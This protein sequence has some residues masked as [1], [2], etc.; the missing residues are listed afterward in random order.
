[1]YEVKKGF[2]YL[3]GKLAR[4]L[5]EESI[6][7]FLGGKT[8]DE[9]AEDKLRAEFDELKKKSKDKKAKL[10][11]DENKRLEELKKLIKNIDD[12][13]Y[14]N[15]EK[16]EEKDETDKLSKLMARDMKS[17]LNSE[18]NLK[19]HLEFT[20][21]KVFTRFPP[22]P[23]GYLH[24]GHA[25]AMRFNFH[26][27]EVVGGHTYLRYDDTNPEKETQEFITNIEENVRWLG[28][29]PY[30][31]TYA[32][33]YFEDLYNLACELIKRG[34]AFVCHQ[35]KQE[36]NEYRVIKQDS[37]YRTRSVEENLKLFEMMRQGRFDE[38][39][40]CLRMK[41][42]MQHNNPCMRDPV[43]YRIKYVPHPHAGDKW[44]IYPTYDFTHCI[45]DS[46]ENI[47]HSLCTLE[48]EI[49]RDSY[50]WLL[51]ALDL[52]RPFV[53]EYSRLNLTRNVLS[54]RK[55]TQLVA[56]NYVKGWDDPR[57]L[58]INGL[59]RRGYTAEAINTFV[60]TV[61]VAR[62]GNDKILSIKLLEYCIRTDLDKNEK[63]RA[64][65][66]LAVVDPIKVT[67]VNFEPDH[68]EEIETPKYPMD[69]EKSEKRKIVLS[70][71]IYIERTDFKEKDEEDFYGL[72][73]GKE[74]GLK[75]AS[76]IKC[77]DIVK[78]NNNHIKELICEYSKEN[79]NIKG[80]IHWI[81][82]KDALKC[83]VRLY[84]YLFNSEDPASL[85]EPLND[86]NQQSLVV[87]TN[88]LVNKSLINEIKEGKK[89][90]QFERLGYF[91]VDHDSDVNNNN[92]VFNLTVDLGDE[93]NKKI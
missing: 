13:L 89:H 39:V 75:Y 35:T 65:R 22:E 18:A 78:D 50:Y 87:R 2:P 53:W 91:V 73:P 77:I 4:K 71:V 21:G 8:N 31:I 51:E 68:S 33:D 92:L 19:K 7:K 44:C 32:S 88:S 85:D 25:K 76:I 23:N 55:L 66:T 81:S 63:N 28:Y 49:R 43:A 26:S 42:D 16:E 15:R 20:G 57:M 52:Y 82:E 48:F 41:I 84:D 10:S 14:K 56:G 72:A 54:K 1:M 93:K 83:E 37:P 46:L 70:K 60:D 29:K 58:T 69:K 27:A 90:F 64:S 67:I 45:H 40:C 61:G 30:K 80:R 3:D 34:K 59:R 17:A 9:L 36:M 38:K 24:I 5:L 79:K 11:E 6:D 86:L 47:T 12:N 62:R 74:V